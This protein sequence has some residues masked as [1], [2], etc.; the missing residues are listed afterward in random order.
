MSYYYPRHVSGLD[1]PILRRN[2]YT[3]TASGILALI[4]GCK[5][6]RLKCALNLVEEIIL[7]Y[8]AWSKKHQIR[9]I[10]HNVKLFKKCW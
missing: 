7:Y 8:D 3:N 10:V 6:H 1:M 4:S 2:N 5:L 9:Y